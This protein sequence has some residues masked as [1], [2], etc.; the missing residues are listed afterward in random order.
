[1]S[2]IK[3]IQTHYKGYHFR[4]RLE[5]RWAVFFD[6]MGYR[7]EY[8][9]EGFVLPSGRNYLPDFKLFDIGKEGCDRDVYVEVKPDS[10]TSQ[11]VIEFGKTVDVIVLVDGSPWNRTYPLFTGLSNKHVVF[12]VSNG[13]PMVSLTKGASSEY[14][15]TAEVWDAICAA[16]SAR[17]EHGQKG[18][19]A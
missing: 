10:V 17:F 18:A 3:P 19:A 9:P 13:R 7:W 4:S 6:K 11:K 1:M 12:V 2:S 16:R 5:A 15:V 14:L 8:E